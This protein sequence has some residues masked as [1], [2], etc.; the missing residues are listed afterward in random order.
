M[1]MVMAMVQNINSGDL[2]SRVEYMSDINKLPDVTKIFISDGRPELVFGI[3]IC[4]NIK[5]GAPSSVMG[6]IDTSLD[7]STYILDNN[8]VNHTYYG[9]IIIN[10]NRFLKV[11]E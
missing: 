5:T 3:P 11:S 10:G 6:L 1:L 2:C 8:E 4:Y 7:N 9:V